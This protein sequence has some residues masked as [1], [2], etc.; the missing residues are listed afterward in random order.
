MKKHADFQKKTVKELKNI[1]SF[2]VNEH[3]TNKCHQIRGTV[4]SGQNNVT[5]LFIRQKKV[6]EHEYLHSYY[7]DSTLN[8]CCEFLSS[9]DICLQ[10]VH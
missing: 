9:D 1:I 5:R 10:S 8:I 3:F 4:L 2:M 7:S 6:Y